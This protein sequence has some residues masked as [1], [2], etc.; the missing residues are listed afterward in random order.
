MIMW[1]K[2]KKSI[3]FIKKNLYYKLIWFDLIIIIILKILFYY[4][5]S[6]MQT[7]N[8]VQLVK[9]ITESIQ[10]SKK[11]AEEVL[12]KLE[13]L[14]VAHAKKGAKVKLGGLGYFVRK[15]KKA[16]TG[17]NPKTGAK[18]KIAA[19]KGFAFKPSSTVK[20]AMNS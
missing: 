8:K 12:S 14:I 20:D 10:I 2:Y 17:V 6:I 9:E 1:T 16:R 11:T 3:V 7:V 13:D 18:I 4:Y 19:S 15:D 5:Y